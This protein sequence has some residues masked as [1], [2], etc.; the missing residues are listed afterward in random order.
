[1]K[2]QQHRGSSLCTKPSC[3]GAPS[4]PSPWGVPLPAVS[5]LPSAPE[6]PPWHRS[7][8][9]APEPLGAWR[10]VGRSYTG[11]R[12]EPTSQ[13]CYSPQ[14]YKNYLLMHCR[15]YRS[16]LLY[17][18]NFFSRC[19]TLHGSNLHNEGELWSELISATCIHTLGCN[20]E[21]NDIEH[22]CWHSST[23]LNEQPCRN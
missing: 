9:W 14:C 19:G 21:I 17:V 8:S 10:R 23:K 6:L 11:S 12:Q 22:Y 3:P 4:H 18:L 16:F 13:R 5:T 1:M 7:L 15:F 20:P 2:F